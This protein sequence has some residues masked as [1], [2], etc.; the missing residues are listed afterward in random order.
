M[1]GCPSYHPVNSV[2]ALNQTSGLASS[3]ARLLNEGALLS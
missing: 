2:K 3:S 1:A